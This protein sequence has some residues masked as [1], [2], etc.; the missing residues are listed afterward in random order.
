MSDTLTAYGVHTLANK[1]LKAEGLEEIAPQM[2][3]SYVSNKLIPS[4]LV[5][6]QKRVKREDAEAWVAKFVANR[7][8]RANEATEVVVTE[9][10]AEETKVAETTEDSTESEEV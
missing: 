8:R 3:Y 5:G 10:P 7:I 4:V 9:A 1:R 2:V 6:D